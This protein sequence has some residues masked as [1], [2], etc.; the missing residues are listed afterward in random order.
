MK[1]LF[2]TVLYF[3]ALNSHIGVLSENIFKKMMNVSQYNFTELIYK[4][5][6][7]N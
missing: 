3:C 4:I 1:K 6:L 2:C 7:T 5:L